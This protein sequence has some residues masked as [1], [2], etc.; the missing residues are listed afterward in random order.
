MKRQTHW[1]IKC[2]LFL[3]A[4][5]L[6]M[7]TQMAHAADQD[8]GFEKHKKET[9]EHMDQMIARAQTM[10]TCVTVRRPTKK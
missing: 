10:K 4:F 6:T 3:A 9:L 8:S 7:T 5:L 2:S 1:M